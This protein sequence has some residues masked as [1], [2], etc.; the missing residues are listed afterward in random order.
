[1]YN[2]AEYWTNR[3]ARNGRLFVA[4]GNKQAEY[5]REKAAVDPF[6]R[7]ALALEPE[8]RTVLDFGCG[9]GRFR[10]ILNEGRS[11]WGVDVVQSEHTM[12]VGDLPTDAFVECVAALFVFQHIVDPAQFERWLTQVYNW[13]IPGGR[14]ILVNHDAPL[15]NPA[16][17]MAQWRA[18]DI[19]DRMPWAEVIEYPERYDGTHWMG[20]LVKGPATD[21]QV[22]HSKPVNEPGIRNVL[23][24]PV[25]VV[26]PATTTMPPGTAHL[27]IPVSASAGMTPDGQPTIEVTVGENHPITVELNGKPFTLNT[28]APP[29]DH[30]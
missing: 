17:H 7:W 29:D 30:G 15:A 2:A 24:T 23:D 11:Y 25:L 18:K 28:V 22:I 4:K 12:H 5:D 6:L 8:V 14:L 16:A 20:V 9:S 13:L 3:A 10:D 19:I 1:M 21:Q 27:G 26:N